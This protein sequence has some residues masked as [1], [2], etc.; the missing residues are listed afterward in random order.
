MI[1]LKKGSVEDTFYH[2]HSSS[3]AMIIQIFKSI[4]I[5]FFFKRMATFL[6]VFGSEATFTNIKNNLKNVFDFLNDYIIIG[7][8]K[9]IHRA[10]RSL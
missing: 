6:F 1:L 7:K 3:G 8:Y 9:H 5:C 2:F 4:M 10:P